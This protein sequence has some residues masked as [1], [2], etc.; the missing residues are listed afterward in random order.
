YVTSNLLTET[1]IN[2]PGWNCSLAALTCTRNDALA[3]G[4]SYPEITV[5]ANVSPSITVGWITY[6]VQVSGGGASLT[7]AHDQT[8]GM[9]TVGPY[10]YLTS[11]HAG[12]FYRGQVGAVYN[13]QVNNIGS[14]VTNG[15]VTV[16][17]PLPSGLIATSISGTGWNCVAPGGPCTRN[18]PLNID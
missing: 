18:D 12:D 1:A 6:G 10:L 14:A 16:S 7:F 11:A 9:P 2:G 4:A 8:M 5:T 13:I 17:D 15:V 3:P